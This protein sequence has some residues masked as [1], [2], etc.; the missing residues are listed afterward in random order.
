MNCEEARLLL[1]ELCDGTLGEQTMRALDA[2]LGGCSEC[3]ALAARMRALSARVGTLPRHVQPAHD[4]WPAIAARIAAG[5]V[6]TG[7]FAGRSRRR[8]PLW[9]AAA[10]AAVLIA[11]TA[12]VTAMLVRSERSAHLASG[13]RPEAPAVAT[14]SLEVS[15]ARGTF[16]AARRQLLAA[17]D[18]RR[19]SLSPA[20]LKVVD[21]NLRIIERAVREM[22]DALARDPGNRELP[23]LLTATYRQEIDVLQ[24]AVGIPARG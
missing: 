3:R 13:P 20:T 10:A 21:E 16:E 5:N 1:D 4:L 9:A 19:S 12:V 18:A 24:C 6:V 14:A 11:V 15:V 2:H 17:L 7:E 22:E 23:A 8:V